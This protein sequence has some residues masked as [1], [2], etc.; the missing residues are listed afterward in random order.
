MRKLSFVLLLTG[1]VAMSQQCLVLDEFNPLLEHTVTEGDYASFPW[2]GNDT[3]L[4]QLYDSLVNAFGGSTLRSETQEWA[5]I[6]IQFWF[7]RIN[8]NNAG[9]NGVFPRELDYQL[10]IDE[11]N[12]AFWLNNIRIRFFI[13]GITNINDESMININNRAERIIN[14]RNPNRRVSN[15]INVHV[16]N[17]GGNE[18][19]WDT[20][21][22]YLNR[23]IYANPANAKI[24]THEV[25]H[26][27]GLLHTHFGHN[28][29]CLREPVSR[30]GVL[31]PP[32]CLPP[33]LT[34]RSLYT[35]DLL[36]DTPADP[37]LSQQTDN[38]NYIGNKK[39]Y[40]KNNYTPDTRNYMSYTGV[41]CEDDFS[42]GQIAVMYYFTFVKRRGQYTL[43]QWFPNDSNDFDRFEPDNAANAARPIVVGERQDHTSHTKGRN[44]VDWVSFTYPIN[45]S[46]G[47]YGIRITNITNNA[48]AN[49]QIFEQQVNLNEGNQV[50]NV[51]VNAV[52]NT[53]NYSIPCA[54]LTPGQTYV[55]RINPTPGY[56]KYQIE[57]IGDIID[58][59]PTIGG[60]ATVCTTN[61]TFT[62]QNRPPNT[63]I[64]WTQS[65]NLSYVSGQGT[66]NY[67]V[68]ATS[69]TTSGNG[70]VQATISTAACGSLPVIRWTVWVG[71]P[72]NIP[73]IS[74]DLM[75]D[76][77]SEICVSSA[78]AYGDFYAGVVGTYSTHFEWQSDAGQ[79]IYPISTDY[80]FTSVM[81]TNYGYRYVRVRPV[82]SCGPGEWTTKYFNLIYSQNCG[83][84][85]GIGG[86]SVATYPNPATDELNVEV[87]DEELICSGLSISISD[88]YNNRYDFG[89]RFEK[90]NTLN[91][92]GLKKGIYLME[93]STEKGK[94]STRII[95]E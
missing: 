84:G 30:G 43:G 25:G 3:Y 61:S 62:I 35:G 75:L 13:Q 56:G 31:S 29:P 11:I 83:G 80:G 90:R 91:I 46:L 4:G 18:F 92:S 66:N 85:G 72:E 28:V 51:T 86:F 38:C 47:N 42:F 74:Y 54:S 5:R 37:N 6:P 24:F 69:S 23:N 22:I 40:Y 19:F 78:S 94:S 2:N 27:L 8:A 79:V 49:I 52:G 76:F 71:P 45:G 48:V 77:P 88:M 7:Y 57:L 60:A 59:M 93:I 15:A 55:I 39:D 12:Y 10:L 95:K 53:V 44:D 1:Y 32:L 17:Q 65:S 34:I 26:Y 14:A 9:G 70:W 58:Q 87:D 63:T 21:A 50:A 16:V 68:K 67:T 89:K 64:Q 82:N 33:G 73:S 20:D 41:D 36:R 81:F